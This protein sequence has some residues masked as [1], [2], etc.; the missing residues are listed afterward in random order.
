[1]LKTRDTNLWYQSSGAGGGGSPKSSS[2]HARSN[3]VC[4]ITIIIL[5]EQEHRSHKTCE[6]IEPS[7]AW[8]GFATHIHLQSTAAPQQIPWQGA[9]RLILRGICCY[10]TTFWGQLFLNDVRLKSPFQKCHSFWCIAPINPPY[11]TLD[12]KRR[13]HWYPQSPPMSLP[14]VVCPLSCRLQ[15]SWWQFGQ[16][17]KDGG[18]ILM[19]FVINFLVA[20]VGN[21]FVRPMV[22]TLLS[23]TQVTQEASLALV[24][25]EN[26]VWEAM[27]TGRHPCLLSGI[28]RQ[29]LVNLRVVWAVYGLW[30]VVRRTMMVWKTAAMGWEVEGLCWS[31]TRTTEQEGWRGLT[32]TGW[33][34][35]PPP[36]SPPPCLRPWHLGM[37][38]SCVAQKLVHKYVLP[39]FLMSERFIPGG[40]F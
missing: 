2:Y 38:Q 11:Q 18:I 33:G 24:S 26:I 25:S 20:V 9:H 10:T 3:N 30:L 8:D 19:V 17:S 15:P 39:V 22:V 40:Q 37:L 12:G 21:L 13:Y 27:C 5:I 16:T 29:K 4:Q 35:P 31:M 34:A 32:A 36:P 23:S 6:N 14:L 7:F 1:M 28:V